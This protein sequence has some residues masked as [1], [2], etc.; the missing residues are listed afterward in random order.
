MRH[1]IALL[2]FALAASGCASKAPRVHIASATAEEIAKANQ[3]REV[4]YHFKEGD[5]VPFSTM[6]FGAGEGVPKA[7]T[8]VRAKQEFYLV[9]RKNMPMTISLDGRNRLQTGS[10]L[11]L[12]TKSDVSDGGQ[13]NWVTYLGSSTEAQKALSQLLE[14]VE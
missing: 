12:V 14:R 4:W 9:F 10:T 1:A 8:A 11:V 6:F 13:V 2:F 5:I 7:P 3:E